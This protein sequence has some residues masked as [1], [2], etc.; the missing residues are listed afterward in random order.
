MRSRV[1]VAFAFAVISCLSSCGGEDPVTPPKTLGISGRVTFGAV[2][3][4]AA[5]VTLSGTATA[6][7]TTSASGDYTFNGLGDGTYSVTASRT[8]YAMSPSGSVV[9]MVGGPGI[10]GLNFAATAAPRTHSI[11]GAVGGTVKQGVRVSLVGADNGMTLTDANGAF[12]FPGLLTGDYVLSPAS[13]GHTFSPLTRNVMGTIAFDHPQT[14]NGT[15]GSVTLSSVVWNAQ[16]ASA[17]FEITSPPADGVGTIRAR[18]L[19]EIAPAQLA[20]YSNMWATGG[21]VVVT[22]STALGADTI[23]LGL[24][25]TPL[26]IATST[27]FSLHETLADSTGNDFVALP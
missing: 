1:R 22:I 11:R 17:F 12:L 21:T 16:D 3:L 23:E 19:A 15:L 4:A 8:G 6:T 18:R 26:C 14:G 2:G 20:V 24:V 5:T 25:R 9:V 27:K 10:T 7:T 13:A